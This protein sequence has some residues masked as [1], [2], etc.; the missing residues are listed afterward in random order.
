MLVDTRVGRLF[1]EVVGEGPEVF[2]WHSFV[3]DG[4]MWR[5]VIDRLSATHRCINIDAPGHGRSSPLRRGFTLD[6]CAEAGVEVMDALGA[7]RAAWAG[8]S[9]GG[10]VG[11]RIAARKPERISGL[12]LFDTSARP[13]RRA[14]KLAEY[15]ALSLAVTLLGPAPFLAQQAVPSFFSPVNVRERPWMI[16]DFVAK[17][18]RMDRASLVFA[19]NAVLFERDDVT[20]ELG[21]IRA[22]TV[23]A[24]GEHDVATPREE[25]EHLAAHVPG[26]TLVVIPRAGHLSALEQPDDAARIVRSIL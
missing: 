1:V 7:K 22:R 4:G 5:P 23:V 14:A 25:S 24:I 17:L 16:E 11:M 12:A 26:A 2:F 3:C 6:E 13:E 10:M 18:V 15:R 19:A 8:L 20:S 9:W 21:H